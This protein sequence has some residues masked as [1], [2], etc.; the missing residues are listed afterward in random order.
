MLPLLLRRRLISAD[1]C[2][3][4]R[5]SRP[6]AVAVQVLRGSEEAPRG[7]FWRLLQQMLLGALRVALLLRL[8][9]RVRAL[10][11]LRGLLAVP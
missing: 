5:A 11:L 3:P 7:R 1:C 4:G 8:L 2:T 6:P 10:P 9:C